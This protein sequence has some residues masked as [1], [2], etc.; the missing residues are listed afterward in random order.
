MHI[1]TVTLN[2]E[3]YPTEEHYPFNLQV[4]HQTKQI[5]FDTPVTMFVGENGS[6][7]STLIK[8]ITGLYLSEDSALTVDGM[9]VNLQNAQCLRELYSIILTA[10][11]SKS[12]LQ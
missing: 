6:G 11:M 7:K 10:P 8:L 1:K 12:R 5:T 9:T 3:Q 2:P 4:F